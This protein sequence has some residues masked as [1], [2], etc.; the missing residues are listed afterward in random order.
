MGE[1][2]PDSM[3][4]LKFRA[5]RLSLRAKGVAA[6]FV[7]MVALLAA[8]FAIYR[9]ELGTQRSDVEAMRCYSV[10]SNLV[11]LQS[12]L[13]DADA[14]M[15]AFFSGAGT[16]LLRDYES[17]TAGAR[18]AL[19]ALI[20][21]A[22]PDRSASLMAARVSTATEEC[23]GSF[24]RL[25]SVGSAG[26]GDLL[27]RARERITEAQ[28]RIREMSRAQDQDLAAVRREREEARQRLLRVALVCGTA[29]PIGALFVHLLLTGRLVRRLN[30]AR[31]NARRLAHGLPL[32]PMPSGADEISD[33]AS[34]IEYTSGLLRERELGLMASERRYRDLFDQAPVP[35]EETDVDGSIRRFN[36]AVCELL[37][38]SPQEVMGRMAWEFADPEQQEQLRGSM[39]GRIAAGAG[40]GPFECDYLLPDGGCIR[41][42]VRETPVRDEWGRVTGVC[43]SLLDVTER[44]MAAVAARKVSAYAF[45]LQS[46]N[47]QLIAA[48]QG[49]RAAGEAK[50]RFVAS[51]SHELRTPLNAIIGFSELMLD[52]A[53]GP[54]TEEQ[55][56]YLGDILSSAR[57]LLDLINDILDLSKL[58]AGKMQFRPE[59]CDLADLLKEVCDVIRPLADKKSLAVSTVVAGPM[60]ASIDPSRFKQVLYNFLSNAVKFTPDGGQIAVRLSLEDGPA[61]RVEV[62]DNG[63]GIAAQELPMLFQEFHQFSNGRASGQGT[64]L[65]LALTKR[66]VEA[67]GGRVEARSTQGEGSVFSAVLPLTLKA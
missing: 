21:G 35:Y 20:E 55:A 12:Y 14:D 23:F 27:A 8:L 22:S 62:E 3:R 66:I 37:R 11:Q 18:A 40:S 32:E 52:G 48:L 45:E 33:L 29:G 25:R 61:A 65:G 19:D 36:Q 57:H 26:H 16:E 10:Q 60:D 43:R 7:P 28:S 49:A 39:L 34:Q 31:E 58:D 4:E 46:R 56:E 6:L 38:R 47:E 2:P 63:I 24:G 41:V 13:L 51:V 67:Q 1:P 50:T 42:E 59:R 15:S 5:P 64:G 53:A 44:N 17:A 30:A 54:T 9:T